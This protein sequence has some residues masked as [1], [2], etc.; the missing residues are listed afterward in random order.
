MSES[1]NLVKDVRAFTV[2]DSVTSLDSF[3]FKSTIPI[4]GE[5]NFLAVIEQD[6]VKV[7]IVRKKYLEV[8][9]PNKELETELLAKIEESVLIEDAAADLL[10]E[11]LETG[12]LID[13]TIHNFDEIITNH[14]LPL[15][16]DELSP[17]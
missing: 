13:E 9:P 6:R 4:H 5:T 14:P 11:S 3:F 8:L 16:E 7:F 2:G 1:N 15:F 10:W 12:L 17:F